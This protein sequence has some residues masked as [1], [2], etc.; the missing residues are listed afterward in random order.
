MPHL[1]VLAQLPRTPTLALATAHHHIVRAQTCNFDTLYAYLSTSNYDFNVRMPNSNHT[2]AIFTVAHLPYADATRCPC[3]VRP[4][5]EP[6][7]QAQH[8]DGDE[9][10]DYALR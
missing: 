7:P 6:A 4:L 8:Q 1:I 5:E 10:R 2:H 3:A 9:P